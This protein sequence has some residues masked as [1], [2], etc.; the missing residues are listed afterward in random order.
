MNHAN[1]L[2]RKVRDLK[3]L[4]Q[5]DNTEEEEE[6]MNWLQTRDSLAPEFQGSTRLA[7]GQKMLATAEK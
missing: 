7:A 6:I 1:N 5:A 4:D 3:V 2:A